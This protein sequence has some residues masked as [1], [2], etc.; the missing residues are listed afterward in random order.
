MNHSHF[1]LL[2]A[3]FSLCLSVV[4]PQAAMANG[5]TGA[6]Q[7]QTD[8]D[9]DSV[10]YGALIGYAVP[11]GTAL[12]CSAGTTKI[13]GTCLETFGTCQGASMNKE[14]DNCPAVANA[15][16]LNTDGDAQGNAC[17]SDDDNDG[18]L[19][20]NDPYP[21]D[22]TRP[23]ADADGDGVVDASDNC[24]AVFNADQLDTDGDAQ[25]DA[26][27]IDLDNDGVV[28]NIDNCPF[29]SNAD[30]LSTDNDYEGNECDADDDNDGVLD[31]IDAAPLDA[32]NTSEI[33]LPVNSSYDGGSIS[34]AQNLQ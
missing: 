32:S 1:R 17:D 29:V 33:I 19:D 31:H 21:L 3:I 22:P 23:N 12:T 5:F 10:G 11:S 15:D 26:C 14:T 18:V 2:I 34:E 16:Q 25:G 4:L 30:Q 9:Y 6:A 20:V 27:D 8:S 13:T 24:P 28:N 7:C